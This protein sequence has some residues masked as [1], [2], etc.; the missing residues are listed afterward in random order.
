METQEFRRQVV[1]G[2]AALAVILLALLL[3]G[4]WSILT[5]MLLIA[6]M[7]GMA[8]ASGILL[9]L[10]FTVWLVCLN[11][12]FTLQPNGAAVMLLFG[13]YTGTVASSGF[14]WANPLYVTRK[15]S[16]RHVNLNTPTIKVNDVRGNPI[17]IAAVMV[18]RVDNTAKAIFDVEDYRNFVNV[19]SE[20]ALRHMAMAYP[21]DVFSETDKISLRGSPDEI[22]QALRAEIQERVAMAGIIIEEARLA[23]LAY[24]SEIAG[25]MLQRQQADALVAARTRIVEGAVGMVE[26]AVERLAEHG[27]VE[28]DE[29][30]KAAMA[31]NLMVVLCGH[32]GAR[33]I[34]NAGTL[35]H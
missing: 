3:L 29:E 13:K 6:E 27:K 5:V 19:Q 2:W 32:E 12:F 30:R 9:L 22:S 4:A 35:Y 24:A 26:M 18:W 21:Y 20:A 25:A 16:L 28:L 7:Y 1:N 14:H 23:H 10:A 17:E 15:V 11:G 8:I 34:V 33:P 31:S